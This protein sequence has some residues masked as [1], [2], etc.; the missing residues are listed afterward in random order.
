MPPRKPWRIRSPVLSFR[1]SLLVTRYCFIKSPTGLPRQG[2]KD[3]VLSRNETRCD[4]RGGTQAAFASL[5]SRFFF[6][7]AAPPGMY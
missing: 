3:P 7:F 4:Q 6:A 5:S 2:L 1:N